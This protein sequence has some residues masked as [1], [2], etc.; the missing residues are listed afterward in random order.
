MTQYKQ[1]KP[2]QKMSQVNEMKWTLSVISI[3]VMTDRYMEESDMR[4]PRG[5]V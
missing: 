2:Q 4:E 5:A 1:I 3:E